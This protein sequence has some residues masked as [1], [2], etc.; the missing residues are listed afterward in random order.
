MLDDGGI[1]AKNMSGSDTRQSCSRIGCNLAKI[2][3]HCHRSPSCST[4]TERAPATM[5]HGAP[6]GAERIDEPLANRHTFLCSSLSPRRCR[7]M[8]FKK[9][10]VLVMYRLTNPSRTPYLYAQCPNAKPYSSTLF[11]SLDVSLGTCILERFLL[12]SRNSHSP[13][14][15]C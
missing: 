13:L 6:T 1:Q 4:P 10:H 3:G 8:L 12:K 11:P 7:E 2:G 9:R 15:H 14:M 5:R